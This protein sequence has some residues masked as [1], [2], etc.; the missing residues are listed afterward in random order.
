MLGLDPC[1]QASLSRGTSF[2]AQSIDQ[3]IMT[4]PGIG[5]MSQPVPEGATRQPEGLTLVYTRWLFAQQAARTEQ[6]LQDA[7]EAAY[8]ASLSSSH[9][10]RPEGLPRGEC[11][12]TN[13]A[14]FLAAYYAEEARIQ[15]ERADRQAA[16]RAAQRAAEDAHHRA[17][18]ARTPRVRRHI[19]T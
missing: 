12:D 15:Q 5:F 10:R 6:A 18:V 2:Q 17:E 3:S 11:T 16:Q 7:R 4:I 19:A 14:R 9:L 1:G 8:Q 13:M